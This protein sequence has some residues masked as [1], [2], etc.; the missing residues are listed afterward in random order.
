[1]T[2]SSTTFGSSDPDVSEQWLAEVFGQVTLDR[3]F[4]WFSQRVAGDDEV[5]VASSRWSGVMGSTVEMD[6]VVI[7]SALA[8]SPWQ[9]RD[10]EGD[11]A[12]APALFRPG[13]PFSARS[14]QGTQLAAFDTD[15][16]QRTA[17]L[18]YADNDL[19]VAFDGAEPVTPKAGQQWLAALD[20]VQAS[21]DSGVLDNGLAR[22][23]AIRLLKV[24][25]LDSF[26]LVGDRHERHQSAERRL[27]IYRAGADFLHEFASLPI[28]IDD[29]ADATGVSVPDLV[30]AFRAHDPEAASPAAV[31]RRA[32]LAAAYDD[33]RAGDPTRGDTVRDIS[34]RW[35][36]SSPSRFAAWFRTAYGVNPKHVLDR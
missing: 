29:A 21:V 22:A 24:A 36:F 33:L 23:S 2:Y 20:L 6:R 17:R 18:L 26:R 35:G 12:A 11:L 13:V 31:L 25:A 27:R 9:N 3:G 5:L 10:G 16:L 1:M 30:E 7:I 19:T 4:G 15:S 28:T 34:L 14:D 32:R 8:P